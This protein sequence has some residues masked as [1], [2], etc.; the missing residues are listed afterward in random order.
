M[1]ANEEG[2]VSWKLIRKVCS[3]GKGNPSISGAS[4]KDFIFSLATEEFSKLE[5]D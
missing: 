2:L 4:E 1:N 3:I 5:A